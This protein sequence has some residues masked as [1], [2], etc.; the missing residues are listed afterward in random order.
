MSG[1][2]VLAPEAR[3]RLTLS[4]AVV[5]RIAQVAATEVDGVLHRTRRGVRAVA[6]LDGTV[7]RLRLRVPLR[8][9]IAA[10]EVVGQIRRQ[11]TVR[12]QELAGVSVRV[13]DIDVNALLPEHEWPVMR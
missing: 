2:P 7:A 10:A 9:P 12:L 1:Q 6:R 5:E 13:C 3:G 8:Y 4:T 11:V